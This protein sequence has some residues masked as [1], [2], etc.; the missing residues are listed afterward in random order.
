MTGWWLIFWVLDSNPDVLQHGHAT[1][2]GVGLVVCI[3]IDVISLGRRL[4]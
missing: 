2:W 4:D 1:A 3:F